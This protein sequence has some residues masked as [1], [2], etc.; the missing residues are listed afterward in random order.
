MGG[1]P[2]FLPFAFQTIDSG[3]GVAGNAGGFFISPRLRIAFAQVSPETAYAFFDDGGAGPD[4]DYDDMVVKIV[5]RTAQIGETPIPAT[6]PLFATGL[7]AL[8]LLTWRGK[9]K[10]VTA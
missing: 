4:R 9:R 7:G 10:A 2:G 1:D 3:G 6:L 5:L 8:G